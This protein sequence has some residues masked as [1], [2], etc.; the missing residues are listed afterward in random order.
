MPTS[1]HIPA[2]LIE[3][4][5]ARARALGVSRNRFI[6]AAIEAKLGESAAWPEPLVRMLGTRPSAAVRRAGQELDR[7]VVARRRTRRGAPAL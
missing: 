1:V 4:L 2:P 5:D 3:R 7:A 6:L